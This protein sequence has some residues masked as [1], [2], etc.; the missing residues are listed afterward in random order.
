MAISDNNDNP[1]IKL[2]C[3]LKSKFGKGILLAKD[4]ED[5]YLDDLSKKTGLAFVGPDKLIQMWNNA[6]KL[7]Y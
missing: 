7:I 1:I 2:L 5:Q 4:I 3:L 6:V